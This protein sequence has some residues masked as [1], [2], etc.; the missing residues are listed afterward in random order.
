M[1]R[2]LHKQTSISRVQ[3]LSKWCIFLWE[4]GLCLSDRSCFSFTSVMSRFRPS[5]GS[6]V[7]VACDSMRR[8]RFDALK[9]LYSVAS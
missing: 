7:E 3:D 6:S 9:C 5:F 1:R 8:G 4:T 2:L